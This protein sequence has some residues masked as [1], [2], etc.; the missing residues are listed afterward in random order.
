M[1]RF[2]ENQK[3]VLNVK[4]KNCGKLR[5]R[6]CLSKTYSYIALAQNNNNIIY[7]EANL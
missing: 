5:E 1:K 2:F 4:D 3:Q 7:T 6:K